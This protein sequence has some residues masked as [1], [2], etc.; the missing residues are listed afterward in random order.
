M[1]GVEDFAMS[2]IGSPDPCALPEQ[3]KKRCLNKKEQ[4]VY[5]PLSG[6][7]RV[8]YD[9][10]AVFVDLGGSHGFQAQLNW[11]LKL[12]GELTVENN[13]MYKVSL[14]DCR[15]RGTVLLKECWKLT[16]EDDKSR[17]MRIT[18]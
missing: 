15:C 4:L 5:A 17:L 14:E 9:K 11:P 2:D 18:C 10:D 3:R 7:G 6:V 13:D 12:E 1:P 16:A 8:L